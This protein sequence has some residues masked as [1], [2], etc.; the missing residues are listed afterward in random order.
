M[1]HSSHSTLRLTKNRTHHLYGPYFCVYGNT[2]VIHISARLTPTSESAPER[3]ELER[4]RVSILLTW[5]ER[6][7]VTDE[8]LELID[9]RYRQALAL[10][11][12]EDLFAEGQL[13][14][15]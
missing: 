4:P 7:A 9:M 14:S 1:H 8:E 5:A 2:T 6:C 11:N 10:M 15:I 3:R 12:V 13:D